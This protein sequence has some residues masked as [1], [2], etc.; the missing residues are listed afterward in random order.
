MR[1]V[2]SGLRKLVRRQATWLTLGLLAGLLA[3]VVIAVGATANRPGAS[4]AERAA[5]LS[6]V[7]FPGAYDAILSFILGL[8]GLFAV[9]YGAAIA[10][11]EWTWGTLKNAVARGES[12]SRYTLLS[13]TSIAVLIAIGL[14]ATFVTGVVAALVGAHLAGTATGGLSDGVTLGRLPGQ[15]ARGCLAVIMEGAMGFTIATLARS[16][17][18]GIG[19]GIGLYFG[20]TFAGIFLPDIVKFLPFNV[21]TA[22]VATGATGGGFGGGAQIASLEANTALV[23]VAFWLVGSLAVAALFTERAEISG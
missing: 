21:A 17:L 8:G 14:A 13:F 5:A 15:F 7:T 11:S 1:L 12:R 4:S 9:I 10:G 3:L 20:E 16:Q 6:L 23:L 18:A 2:L 19:A 22:S